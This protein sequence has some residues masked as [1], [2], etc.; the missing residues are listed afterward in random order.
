MNIMELD[1]NVQGEERRKLVQII[2]EITDI[3]AVYKKVPTC[4]G[5]FF[6]VCQVKCVN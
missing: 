5:V 2:S 6:W 4:T 3:A 1:Y